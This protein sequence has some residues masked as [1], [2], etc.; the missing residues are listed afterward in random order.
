[1]LNLVSVHVCMLLLGPA[2]RACTLP[3]AAHPWPVHS[4]VLYLTI[5]IEA[6]NLDSPYG[7]NSR[8]CWQ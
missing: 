3:A 4:V 6:Q 7:G 5:A 1:M 8:H 2:R